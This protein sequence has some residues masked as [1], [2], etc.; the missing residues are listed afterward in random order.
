MTLL[1][2]I[3]FASL[4]AYT[5][6]PTEADAHRARNFVIGDLKHDRVLRS[7]GV[8]ASEFVARR[9]AE[10][11]HETP[12][13]EWLNPKVALIAAPRSSPLSDGA[14]WVP[15]R[16]ANALVR[17]R[18]GRA[19]TR[20]LNRTWPVTKSAYTSSARDRPTPRAHLD[21][22][23]LVA[24]LENLDDI[25]VIDDVVTTGATLL[26]AASRLRVA[27]PDAR[28]RAFSVVRAVGPL[29]FQQLFDP[30]TGT[31]TLRRNGRARREP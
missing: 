22:I 27:F 7:L 31:I 4:L 8:A 5:S 14:L 25:L 16:L 1:S 24:G 29:E 12:F 26:G 30:R 21:S 3:E 28:I 10:R 2:E 18:L 20:Q 23:E 17:A 6:Q 19:T 13:A 15:N 11:L 9:L